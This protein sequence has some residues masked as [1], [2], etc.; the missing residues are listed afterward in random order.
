MP[1]GRYRVVSAGTTYGTLLNMVNRGW[2]SN[3]QSRPRLQ[4]AAARGVSKNRSK[5]RSNRTALEPLLLVLVACARNVK[6][7]SGKVFFMFEF[8]VNVFFSCKIYQFILSQNLHAL[9]LSFV[10]R[11]SFDFLNLRVSLHFVLSSFVR[12]AVYVFIFLWYH[13]I[14]I[15]LLSR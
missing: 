1:I 4:G 8:I 12:Y 10:V 6:H 11:V 3:T 13:C 7:C 2:M 15:L 14:L 9:Y 5:Q